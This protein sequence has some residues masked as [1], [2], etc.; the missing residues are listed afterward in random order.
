[1]IKLLLFAVMPMNTVRC[2][3]DE[4]KVTCHGFDDPPRMIE[5]LKTQEEKLDKYGKVCREIR[6]FV[7]GL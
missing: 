6:S 5:G 3:P 7:D 2:F 1:M 4:T